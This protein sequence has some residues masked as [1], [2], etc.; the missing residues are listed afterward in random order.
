MRFQRQFAALD[1][2]IET[3]RMYRGM[4]FD[5]TVITQLELVKN[6]WYM[7]GDRVEVLEQYS[8]I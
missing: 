2:F 3:L 8:L 4:D 6:D 5:V 1:R 7:S